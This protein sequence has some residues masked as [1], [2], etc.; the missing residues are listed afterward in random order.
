M[1]NKK[2]ILFACSSNLDRSP[3]AVS[4]FKNSLVYEAKSCGIL[5]HAETCVSEE[6][7]RWA[8]TIFCMEEIHKAHLLRNFKEARMKEIR[9][10]S[11][12]STFLRNDPKLKEVLKEKLKG[13]L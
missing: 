6:L 3:A 5:P 2:K 8:D 9:V 1:A 4:L 10:L 12:D 11:V 7:I 13:F